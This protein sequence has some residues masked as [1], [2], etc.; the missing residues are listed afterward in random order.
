MLWSSGQSP[1]PCK[2]SA[3]AL[4]R[5]AIERGLPKL[6]PC[7]SA[8]EALKHADLPSRKVEICMLWI[9]PVMPSAALRIRLWRA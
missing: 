4:Y 5:N 7:G 6:K 3:K 8:E 9:M 1:A 2:D